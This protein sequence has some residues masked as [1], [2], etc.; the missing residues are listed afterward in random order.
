MLLGSNKVLAIDTTKSGPNSFFFTQA[1]FTLSDSGVNS[2]K[3][4][5]APVLGF[6]Y[7]PRF[8]KSLFGNDDTVIRGGFRVGYDE[9]FNNI[10]ANL[11]LNAPF[12]LTTTQNNATQGGKFPWAV[13]FNQN[14]PL[15]K[16]VGKQAPELRR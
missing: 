10:P 8:A 12:T 4:N 16:N 1:P 5:F 6:A 15:V 7:T 14:V 13:G 2:D 9:I 3:N 11:G